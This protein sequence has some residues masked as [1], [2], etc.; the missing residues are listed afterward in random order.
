MTD[1]DPE[2]SREAAP[3]FLTLEPG[4]GVYDFEVLSLGAICYAAI[5]TCYSEASKKML[6]T[7]YGCSKK[8]NYKAMSL[9]LNKVGSILNEMLKLEIMKA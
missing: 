6:P 3:G 2:P 5:D 1:H 7:K 4:D 9:S 8:D